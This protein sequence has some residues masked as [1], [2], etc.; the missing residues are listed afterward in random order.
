MPSRVSRAAE[1]RPTCRV[2]WSLASAIGHGAIVR[3]QPVIRGPS[4]SATRPSAEQARPDRLAA[5]ETGDVLEGAARVPRAKTHGRVDVRLAVRRP[6]ATARN[7]SLTIARRIRSTI[8]SAVRRSPPGA[9]ANPSA[10]TAT[11]PSTYR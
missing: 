6:S 7:A 8:A 4:S 11:P 1:M 2:I 10:G 5:A 9:S 3:L